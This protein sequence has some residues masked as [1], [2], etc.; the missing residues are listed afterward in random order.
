MYR[1]CNGN[2]L[3]LTFTF[4]RQFPTVPLS[5][6]FRFRLFDKVSNSAFVFQLNKT[7]VYSVSFDGVIACSFVRMW[8]L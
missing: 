7:E 2:C 4:H 8:I 6:Y 1:S 5:C 3:L